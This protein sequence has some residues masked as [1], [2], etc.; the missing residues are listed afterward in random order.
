MI[1]NTVYRPIPPLETNK[2]LTNNGTD[3]QWTDSPVLAGLT[4]TNQLFV[5]TVNKNAGFGMYVLH[6][7]TTGKQNFGFGQRVLYSCQDGNYNAGFG[8]YC[9]HDLIS[10]EYNTAGGYFAGASL[11]GGRH[12]LFGALAGTNILQAELDTCYGYHSGELLTTGGQNAFFGPF[13]GCW[14]TT[15]SKIII[16]DN[17][18]RGSYANEI[19]NAMIYGV[20][21][22]DPANQT[23]RLNAAVTVGALTIGSITDAL[24]ATSGIVAAVGSPTKNYVLMYNGSSPVWAASGTTFTFSI[25]TFSQS[26]GTT[27]ALIGTGAWKAI[28][29]LSFS[30]TYNN[31]YADP[32]PYVAIS[33]AGNSPA[34][35]NMTPAAPDTHRYEGATTNPE[36]INWPSANGGRITFTLY[37]QAGAETSNNTIYSMYFY[38]HFVY[39]DLDH[40]SGFNNADIAAM[41][42]QHEVISSTTARSFTLSIG[43]S[44]Y[45][46]FS[47]RTGDT[48][49]AQV[50]CG[51]GN[52]V[53]TVAMNK[54]DATAV[55]PL[56]ETVEHTNANGKV[57]NFYVYGSKLQNIDAHSTTFI[58]SASSTPQNYLYYGK[59][60]KA[61]SY[62]E[63][64][65]EG[66]SVQVISS[67]TLAR[68]WTA[69]TLSNE[70]ILIAFPTRLGTPT[71]K[72]NATGFAVDMQSPEVVT[73]TNACGFQENYNVFRSTNL[74]TYTGFVLLTA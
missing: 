28:G 43:V 62:T 38:N 69:Q 20:S 53:I 25:A 73:I 74:Q 42:A 30:A 11:L 16:I 13:S 37:A 5:D 63:S 1:L 44:N 50:Q 49:V 7:L 31:P 66:L 40:N 70:Y 55:A 36:A 59:T 64:D 10:G 65:V 61:S 27:T 8:D 2:L 72:D 71:F 41:A 14:H 6:S 48:A 45:L 33:G 15:Q 4:V 51:T 19:T 12:T 9:L 24:K 57:E 35:I 26:A 52:D 3:L 22:V 21:A 54:N 32:T 68:V 17:V 56:K 29:A 47:H 23:L 60:S 18:D 46:C 58:T 67:N 34:N 39:Y